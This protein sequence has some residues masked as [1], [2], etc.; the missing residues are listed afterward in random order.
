[1]NVI[2]STISMVIALQRHIVGIKTLSL[3]EV[4]YN[5]LIDGISI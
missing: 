1:M 3:H 5:Y 2:I 4:L